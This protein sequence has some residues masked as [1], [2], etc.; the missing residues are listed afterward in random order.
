LADAR[1]DA[2]SCATC[3]LKVQYECFQDG[4]AV[5]QL[6][7]GVNVINTGP[8]PIA[9]STVTVR[10]WYTADNTGTQE[11]QCD[12][13]NLGCSSVSLS[14]HGV[15][16]NKTNADTYI[17]VAFTGSTMLAPNASTGEVRIT[18]VKTGVPS[19]NQAN[20]YSF[21]STGASYVDAPSLTAYAGGRLLWGTEPP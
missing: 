3:S 6:E 5:T 8:A 17:E 21:R 13:A 15:T 1:S 18:V 7:M 19:Y 2:P 20:D 11:P 9:L 10:Y 16:P 12:S 14:A 4:G